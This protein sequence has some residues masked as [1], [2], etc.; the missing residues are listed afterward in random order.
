M[1]LIALGLNH[2]TA[3]LT[4]REREEAHGYGHSHPQWVM[5][6]KLAQDLPQLEAGLFPP[7]P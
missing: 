6:E 2:Q 7:A 4:L 1:P 5:G 3:P